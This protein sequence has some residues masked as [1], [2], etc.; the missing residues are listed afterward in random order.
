MVKAF[1]PPDDHISLLENK[2]IA[3]LLTC[4][5]PVENNTEPI[6]T[7]F[8][9]LGFYI[10]GKIA[11]KFILPLCADIKVAKAE[12]GKLAERMAESIV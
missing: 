7:S 3:L 9:K 10:K 1:A 11:G 4:G 2:K 5:G 12:G 6:Q 8:E